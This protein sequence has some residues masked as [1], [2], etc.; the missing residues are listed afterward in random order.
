MSSTVLDLFHFQATYLTKLVANIPEDRLYEQQL[1]GHNSAGWILGHLCVEAEDVFRHI[2]APYELVDDH[3]ALWFKNTTGKIDSLEGLPSK[4]TLLD[5]FKDRY[6][7][8]AII[9]ENLTE[10]QRV[11]PHPSTMLKD[12][13]NNLDAWYAHHL[14]THISIHCGNLAIWKKMIGLEVGGY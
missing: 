14:T 3:W 11:S 4:E 5:V 7:L 1:E 2:D 13:F 12:V 6:D 9:Y 8:L 10:G